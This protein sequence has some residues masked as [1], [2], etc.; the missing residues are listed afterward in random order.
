MKEDPM[1]S[2]ISTEPEPLSTPEVKDINTSKEIENKE[3]EIDQ[4]NGTEPTTDIKEIVK[5]ESI[6]EK[7]REFL[8]EHLDLLED[9][10]YDILTSWIISTWHFDKLNE[11]AYLMFKGMKGSGKT[12]CLNVLD[13]VCFNPLNTAS[14]T[15]PALYRVLDDEH[16]T[17]LIDEFDLSQGKKKEML[18][19]ILNAGYERGQKA[20]LCVPKLG[21]GWRHK[22]FSVFGPKAVCTIDDVSDTF[23]HR[24]IEITMFKNDRKIKFRIDEE[25]AKDLKIKLEKYRK[26]N[27][28]RELEATE[29]LFFND[30]YNIEE[31]R[32][33]QMMNSLVAVTPDKYRKRLLDYAVQLEMERSNDEELEIYYEIFEA[34]ENMNI[35]N[36]KKIA[37]N[38]IA[39][40]V[41]ALRSKFDR[42]SNKQIGSHMSTM[43]MKKTCRLPD[44]RSGRYVNPKL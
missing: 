37:I 19:C 14:I 41:N 5:D 20:V 15:T 44:G 17:I 6:Y 36:E 22:E 30:P 13:K 31:Y 8:Y 43:G 35:T 33:V 26:D 23:T 12:R 9:I 3:D 1:E 18:T 2:Q 42:I 11:T 38:D 34:L 39:E 21:G 25:K 24:C 16:T 7:L 4:S 28:D 27:I 32:L 40:H 10:H 29:H